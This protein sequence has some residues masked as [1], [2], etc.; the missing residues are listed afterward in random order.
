MIELN[1]LQD[2]QK[3]QINLTPNILLRKPKV[4]GNGTRI[5]PSDGAHDSGK[6]VALNQ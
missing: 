5:R 4:P 2:V 6:I 3:F 1:C